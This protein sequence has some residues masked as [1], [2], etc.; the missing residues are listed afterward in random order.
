[1]RSQK[2]ASTLKVPSTHVAMLLF[3]IVVASWGGTW[4][5]IKV[6]VAEV[7]PLWA[8]AIRNGAAAV[9]LALLLMVTGRFIVPRRGDWP[10]VLV[11]SLC[12][13]TVFV[14]LM[15]IGL[16]Y[17]PVG[18]SIMVGYT[19]PL[20]VAPAAWLFLKEPMPARR[21]IGVII[22]L[23]GTCMLFKPGAFDWHNHNAVMG[24]GL[25]L[26]SALFWSASIL[27]TRVHRW[28]STPLQLVPW[29]AL[30]SAIVLTILASAF[31]GTPHFAPSVKLISAFGYCSIVGVAIAYWA[32]TIVNS[33]L[34]ATTTSLGV[35]ATPIVGMAISAFLL[36]EKIDTGLLVSAA[37]IIFGIALG[38][39]AGTRSH[40]ASTR[41]LTAEAKQ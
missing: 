21:I 13:M 27:Y 26:L 28:V 15:T 1:M 14:V 16:K 25:L 6:I 17:V 24:N 10:I 40:L 18:R 5:V 38:T 22:G 30:I 8:I 31:E 29:Q 2:L 4:V 9:G 7:P 37:M 12:H 36:G 32:M 41:P 19:T 34:P 35:L 23:I 11:T 3:G 39:T 33:S 20:W